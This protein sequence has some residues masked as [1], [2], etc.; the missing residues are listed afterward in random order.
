MQKNKI[1]IPIVLYLG[2]LYVSAIVGFWYAG[3]K[4]WTNWDYQLLDKYY[5]KAVIAGRGPEKSSQIIYLDITDK[6]YQAIG[7]DI[8]ERE[9]LS[10]VNFV[11]ADLGVEAVFYDIVFTRPEKTEINENF[12]ESLNNLNVTY[13]PVL[14][15]EPVYSPV[16]FIWKSG[17]GYE[18]LREIVAA[19]P[20][21]KGASSPLIC[22]EG[23]F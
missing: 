11:L 21:E 10:R 8:S 13:F 20:V 4:I 19:H 9:Y 17:I 7:E 12:V 5:Q 14:F 22:I 6:T 2:I 23:D 1:Q 15:A 3:E 16:P 18:R